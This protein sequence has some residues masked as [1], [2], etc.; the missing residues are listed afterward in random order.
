VEATVRATLAVYNTRQDIDALVEAL[1]ELAG[2]A[3]G[4]L[5]RAR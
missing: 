5:R 2:A 1:Q 3:Q 4:A